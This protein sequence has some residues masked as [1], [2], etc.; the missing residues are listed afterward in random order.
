VLEVAQDCN[1]HCTYCY[2]EGGSYGKPA[3]LLDSEEAR[4]A[5]RSLIEGAGERETVT[6]I[7]F[8]GEP[9]LNLTALEAALEE[10]ENRGKAAGKKVIPSLTTNGTLLGPE[11]IDLIR[12]Y[13]VTVSVSMDG[14]PDLHDSNRPTCKGEGSYER[15]VANLAPLLEN[16]PAPV[17]A[18]VTLVPSQWSR[19]EEVFDHLVSIGFHEVGIAPASPIRHDLL[20]NESQEEDLLQGFAALSKRFVTAARQG[21]ILPFTNLIDLLARLHLG[22]TKSVSCGAGLGYLAVDA[23]GGYYLCHRLAGDPSF[24]VGSLAAGPDPV[25]IRSV[26][27]SVTAGLDTLCENCWARTLCS[28]GCHYENHLRQTHLGLGPGSSCSFIRRWLQ[29]GIETYA[30]LKRSDCDQIL[31]L[32]EKRVSC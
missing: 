21:K 23:E 26:L 19:V 31:R 5:V 1:L 28:G 7:L 3:R 30:E 14:P 16:S 20:P 9:L 8:G 13:G 32:F 15:I 22:Q 4:R 24:R 10:A 12:R 29:A 27:D 18:R 6:L 17:A 2:A 25:K 11:A